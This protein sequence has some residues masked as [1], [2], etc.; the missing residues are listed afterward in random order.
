LQSPLT[1]CTLAFASAAAVLAVIRLR[2]TERGARFVESL[3]LALPI[4]GTVVKKATIGRFARTL[5]TLLRSGVALVPALEIV[6]DVVSGERF[7]ES[8]AEL[9]QALREGSLVSGPLERSGLYE[10]M[11]VQLLRVGEETGSLDA[12][13]LRIAEYYELDVETM[14]AALGSMLEPLMIL[15]LGGAVGFIVAAVFIPLYTL[16]GNI[17]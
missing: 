1:W 10:P 7:R 3:L 17:K 11:F 13:L 14:L 16:I 6:G 5:G 4:A 2:S 15:L 12:M 9:R 8:I